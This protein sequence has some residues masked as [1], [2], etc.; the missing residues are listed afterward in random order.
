M[1]DWRSVVHV[2]CVNIEA[3]FD[4]DIGISEVVGLHRRVIALVKGSLISRAQSEADKIPRSGLVKHLDLESV[5]LKFLPSCHARLDVSRQSAKI[6]PKLDDA[7]GRGWA[8]RRRHWR[9]ITTTMN[10][11]PNKIGAVTF[12][13]RK[14]IIFRRF[15]NV[16]WLCGAVL[17]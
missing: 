17:S 9:H 6:V 10:Q 3:S 13:A 16:H 12:V 15:G 1:V 5:F 4:G 8:S 2:V 11:I 7:S 14:R